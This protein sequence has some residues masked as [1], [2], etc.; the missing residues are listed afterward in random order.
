M[1]YWERLKVIDVMQ[2]DLCRSENGHSNQM[3][4]SWD[5][6]FKKKVKTFTCLVRA[7]TV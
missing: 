2:I 1:G 4:G 3:G 5:K 7:S 6:A